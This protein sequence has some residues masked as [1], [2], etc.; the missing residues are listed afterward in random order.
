MHGINTVKL[1]IDEKE[2][3]D[4]FLGQSQFSNTDHNSF[5]DRTGTKVWTNS[6][7]KRWKL[8]F[9]VSWLTVCSKKVFSIYKF[10]HSDKNMSRSKP[11]FYF[12]CTYKYFTVNFLIP[13]RVLRAFTGVLN[14][15]LAQFQ[16]LCSFPGFICSW[17][18]N[19][20]NQS[21]VVKM[22]LVRR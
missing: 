14:S 4:W 22:L 13:V 9:F 18:S 16:L 11:L 15:T 1:V 19:V 7:I 12:L 10:N 17:K 3:F 20:V 8:I 2:Y 5:L 6:S 21:M